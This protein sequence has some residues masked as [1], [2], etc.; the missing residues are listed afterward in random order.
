[1]RRSMSARSNRCA[2]AASSARRGSP[3]AVTSK[4]IAPSRIASTSRIA[5]SSSTT[6]TFRV[7]GARASLLLSAALQTKVDLLQ[8]LEV[9][10]TLGEV[11]AEPRDLPLEGEDRRQRVP[12][13]PGAPRLGAVAAL[14]EIRVVRR[15]RRGVVALLS[16]AVGLRELRRT[17]QRPWGKDAQPPARRITSVATAIVL[18]SAAGAR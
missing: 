2:A 3:T 7:T 10:L 15:H 16:E 13:H 1:M 6:R 4:P 12:A 17:P 5:A 8:P 14:R 9:G 11:L 18:K